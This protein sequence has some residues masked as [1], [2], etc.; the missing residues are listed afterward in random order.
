MKR[1]L[2][3][4]VIIFLS[5][6]VMFSFKA[7]SQEAQDKAAE[8]EKKESVE[9]KSE[10]AKA[11]EP[12]SA[13]IVQEVILE[14]FE[15]SQYG[16]N[17]IQF[18]ATTNQ[19]AGIAIRDQFPAPA[20]NSKKYLGVKVLGRRGDIINIIPAKKLTIDKQ[21]KSISMWVY[22]KNFP[23]EISIMLR[24]AANT[25]H[26]LIMGNLDYLGWRKLSVNIPP[27]VK[28]SD[29]HLSQKREI[30]ITRIM[31]NPGNIGHVLKQ[32]YIYVDDISANVRDKFYDRQSDEW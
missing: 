9:K 24:D 32:S 22:G 6:A 17:N 16:N 2:L 7:N 27:T 1:A 12:K 30:E 18:K 20:N 23:G 19:S 11:A 10:A 15:S 25:S 26:R 29:E 4:A 31:Y 5:V 21:C 14:D 3:T 28:Q 8:P 13:R